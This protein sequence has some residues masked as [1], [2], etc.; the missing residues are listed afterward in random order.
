MCL[1]FLHDRAAVPPR[2]R[3]VELGVAA[4]DTLLS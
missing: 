1:C 2:I 3:K 4:E